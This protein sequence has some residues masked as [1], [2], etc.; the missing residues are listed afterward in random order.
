MVQNHALN[1]SP[2]KP[3]L[4]QVTDTTRE[5]SAW[6]TQFKGSTRAHGSGRGPE[7]ASH[8]QASWTVR[9][10]AGRALDPWILPT[11]PGTLIPAV[12]CGKNRCTGRSVLT[13]DDTQVC[14]P[15]PAQGSLSSSLSGWASAASAAAG[16]SAPGEETPATEAQEPPAPAHLPTSWGPKM[17]RLSFFFHRQ[18]S[19]VPER[20]T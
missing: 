8:D 6:M 13:E 9:E 18:Q 3:T 1:D 17:Q 7:L 4:Q 2:R 20:D 14:G 5:K 10:A 11:L 16:K 15:S 19:L 12:W